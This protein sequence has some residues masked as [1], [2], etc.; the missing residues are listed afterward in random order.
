MGRLWVIPCILAFLHYYQ[1]TILRDPECRLLMG[2]FSNVYRG[3]LAYGLI[4]EKTA[5]KAEQCIGLCLD[6]TDCKSVDYN[7]VAKK[8][9][10]LSKVCTAFSKTI[11]VISSII[12]ALHR[13][14]FL[15]F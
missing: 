8:C 11:F 1:A 15:T 4:D 12:L 14:S 5:D 6:H 10:R 3:K 2:T 13:L 7:E 9:F